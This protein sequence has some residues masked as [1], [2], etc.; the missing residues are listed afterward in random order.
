V[1]QHLQAE[2]ENHQRRWS[3]LADTLQRQWDAP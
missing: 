2:Y 3:R 1:Q